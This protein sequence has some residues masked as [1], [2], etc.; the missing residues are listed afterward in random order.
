MAFKVLIYV[1]VLE[2]LTEFAE[3]CYVPKK[4]VVGGYLKK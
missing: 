2:L 3:A 4:G 1:F